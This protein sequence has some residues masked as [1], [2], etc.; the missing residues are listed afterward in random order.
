MV[1]GVVSDKV[2]KQIAD[3]VVDCSGLNCPLPIVKTRQA[4]MKM[5]SGQVIK[6]IS[7]D[8]SSIDDFPRF[9]KATKNPLLSVEDK[10]GYWVYYIEVN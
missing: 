7:T 6:V 1:F 9:A 5:S 4:M 3:V 10:G 2:A 8:K